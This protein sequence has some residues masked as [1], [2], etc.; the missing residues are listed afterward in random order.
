[1]GAGKGTGG[2][3]RRAPSMCGVSW[4][5]P[6]APFPAPGAF[7][8][9]SPLLPSSLFSRRTQH[10]D[11]HSCHS[12]RYYNRR[13]YKLVNT[14]RRREGGGGGRNDVCGAGSSTFD[15]RFSM[16]TPCR[17]MREGEGGGVKPPRRPSPTLQR[18][19][20]P[21]LLLPSRVCR[22][23]LSRACVYRKSAPLGGFSAQKCIWQPARAWMC[24]CVCCAYT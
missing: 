20:P 12:S 2:V 5:T 19:A 11:H 22:A 24:V 13:H 17:V 9:P 7:P 21:F 18:S 16:K 15:P 23:C 6:P 3:N 1:M 14:G 10:H 4:S 8:C